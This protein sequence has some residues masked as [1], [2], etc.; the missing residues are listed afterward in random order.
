MLRLDRR[1]PIAFELDIS[2][3][4]VSLAAVFT[5]LERLVVEV[6]GNEKH[7]YILRL[8]A[9][10]R[11]VKIESVVVTSRPI[12]R[13]LLNQIEPVMEVSESFLDGLDDMQ[14]NDNFSAVVICSLVDMTKSFAMLRVSHIHLLNQV[15]V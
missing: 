13:D 3:K 14:P 6:D 2:P 12:R 11:P 15:R 8:E 4:K 7:R 10:E 9:L 1:F 5:L